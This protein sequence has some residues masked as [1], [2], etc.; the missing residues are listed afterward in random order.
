AAP[1]GIARAD[2]LAVGAELAEGTAGRGLQRLEQAS[3]RPVTRTA[4][5]NLASNDGWRRLDAAA[6]DA[7]PAVL[8]QLATR[9]RRGAAAER[10]VEPLPAAAKRARARAQGLAR[11]AAVA[12]EA[13]PAAP[14]TTTNERV[15][16]AKRVRAAKSA[17]KPA[18]KKPAAGK[19]SS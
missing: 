6:L 19:P 4:L 7:T 17:I 18:A 3:P 5:I 14:A 13:A 2:V 10:A 1:A 9:L 15:P 12:P 11:Q 8:P 16:A